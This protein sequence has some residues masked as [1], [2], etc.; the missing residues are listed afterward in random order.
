METDPYAIARHMFGLALRHFRTQAGLSLRELGKHCHYDYSRLSR[1]ETGEHLGDEAMLASLD[2]ILGAGG[3]LTALRT[4]AQPPANLTAAVIPLPSEIL[5]PTDGDPVMLEIRQPDGR[6]VRVS[7]SRREFGHLL[8]TGALR[9]ALPAG[10]LNLDEADRIAHTMDQPSRLDPQAIEYYRRLLTEHYTAD[11]MLGPRQLLGPAMAQLDILDS[12]RAHARPPAATPLLRVLAQYAE[13]VGWLHQDAGDLYAALYWSDRASQ[14]AQTAGDYQMVAYLLIRKSNIACLADDAT[15]VIE[16]AA[17]AQNVP[18]DIDP[19]IIALAA[20]QE[21][22]GWAMIG[23]PDHCCLKLDTAADLLRD[24]SHET[25]PTAPEYIHHYGLDTLE[26]QSASCYRSLGR[27][28]DAIAILE[29]KI[30]AMPGNLHR[31]RGH[32]ISKLAN[33]LLATKHPEPE[34]AADLGVTCVGLA[35][36]TGSARIIKEL[37]ALDTTLTARWPGLAA[38]RA[39]HDALA[40]R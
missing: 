2:Q 33:A 31:D 17:A 32:Q 15:T 3:L 12:L 4:A 5:H 18:A 6:S 39:L 26:E 10:V 24:H 22:R 30:A 38:A 21:A 28:E 23:D 16:L 20:Q 8:G 40:V 1:M 19:K 29:R 11:K 25:D 7:I 27:A 13:F 14:W 37:H 34:K 35:R 9:A 36:Q